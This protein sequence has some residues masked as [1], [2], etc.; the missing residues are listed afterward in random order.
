MNAEKE[1]V[2]RAI[3]SGCVEAY[4]SGFYDCKSSRKNNN[5]YVSSL[6]YFLDSNT[7][8]LMDKIAIKL[9]TLNFG[10]HKCNNIKLLV[11][12]QNLILADNKCLW[13]IIC[14]SKYGYDIV[15]DE[16]KKACCCVKRMIKK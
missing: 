5:Y 11:S 9:A 1:K 13:S 12:N 3:V 10:L 16:Y 2:I 8:S 15:V 6:A 4:A 7:R 14:K